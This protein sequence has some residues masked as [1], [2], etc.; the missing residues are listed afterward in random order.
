MLPIDGKV[1]G[2][3]QQLTN[4][5]DETAPLPPDGI[6]CLQQITGTLLYYAQAVDPTML[7][8]LGIITAQQSN[9]MEATA[10][11]IVQ[12][13]NYSATHPVSTIRFRSS[14]MILRI[15]SNASYLTEAKARS[16][17]GGHFYLVTN[18]P[19][20]R[21]STMELSLQRP[22]SC[23]ISCP[24]QPRQNVVCYSTTKR[25]ALY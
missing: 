20:T 5:E 18:L 22:P 25:I 12:L 2:T 14:D 4:P 19:S 16:R 7:M 1:Y 13:L 3:N 21:M 24:W 17:L 8:A 9:G 15:H 23:G 6:K 10:E 11:A